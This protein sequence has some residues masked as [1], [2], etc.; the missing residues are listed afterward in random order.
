MRSELGKIKR[1][2]FGKGGY[3]DVCIGISFTLGGSG[4]GVTDFWGAWGIERSEYSK[5]TEEERIEQ[6]G[7]TT[8]RINKL[9][10]DAK[11]DSVEKLEGI[12]IRV[13]FNGMTLDSW[14]VLKEVL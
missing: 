9:L 14:E 4:W 6:L 12:P 7:K 8:M 1:A 5:W 10:D 11:V 2:S 13:N 3:Q